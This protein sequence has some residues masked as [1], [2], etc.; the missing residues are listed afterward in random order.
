MRHNRGKDMKLKHKLPLMNL[1]LL[2][3]GFI[4][5][6]IGSINALQNFVATNQKEMAFEKIGM[7]AREIENTINRGIK[8][9]TMMSENES[10]K[11]MQWDLIKPY[12]MHRLE[13]SPFNKVGI[14]FP[15][16]SYYITS[17]P[18]QSNLAERQ[19]VNDALKGNTVISEPLYSKSD[20]AYQ[21]VIAMPILENDE[22]KGLIIGGILMQDIE[23]MIKALNINQSGY[24]FLSNN[25]GEIIIH[26]KLEN[27][28]NRNMYN[29]LQL[30]TNGFNNTSGNLT[31]KDMKGVTSYAFY[32]YLELPGWYVVISVPQR[33]IYKPI[34]G[35][36]I[37]TTLV[38]LIVLLILGI[39]IYTIVKRFFRPIDR[40]VSDMKRVESGEYA[41][42][43]PVH[44]EDEIGEI[45]RQFNNTI[46]GI[47]LRDEELQALNEE[48]AASFEEING[49]NEKLT[50]AHEAISN[51][52]MKQ[53]MIN[54]LGENLYLISD[55]EELLTTILLHTGEMINSKKSAIFILN[56][57]TNCFS[58]ISA[59]N[60]T[61]EERQHLV[62]Q[63]DEGAFK[64][65]LENKTEL[66]IENI[67]QDYRYKDITNEMDNKML[68]Q[69]PIFD[70]DNEVIGV[71]SYSSDN[72]N[73]DFIPFVKQIS[74]IISI[75][76][77]NTSLITQMKSTYF[78]I[79]VALVKAMELKDTYTKG[80]SERVMNYSLMMGK[81]LNLSKDEIEILRHGSI[82]HDIG[83]LGVPENLLTKSSTLDLD[84]Y[85]MIKNHPSIGEAFISNMKFLDDVKPIIRNH[86][87][88]IDGEGYPDGLLGDNIPL[89]AKIVAIA[90]AYDAMTSQ[91]SYR[92]SMLMED[93]IEELKQHSGTQFDAELVEL[94]IR[95]ISQ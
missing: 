77:L 30:N 16:K 58:I 44:R 64:W 39:G 51:N 32:N 33:D 29:Y 83:K 75:T 7:Q 41:I 45:T 67:N 36:L 24:G 14:V 40:L 21:I 27:L 72:L 53:K 94:F 78:D 59:E 34:T 49:A 19:Y 18:V 55:Y 88:R 68:L 63:K 85:D 26:P 3:L 20:G 42:Q 4:M 62:F 2:I 66:F 87:E 22:V 52:L 37:K 15:D 92:L 28:V 46:E 84:E 73:L 70:E 5:L 31:Y 69:L 13:D 11:T 80:H 61:M 65:I 6:W 81:E 43:V 25:Q 89:L 79:I 12:A 50:F 82:L 76:I 17:N 74:K 71:I 86:H 8:Q 90:D 57:E 23:D 93:A 47:S 91:R 38:F 48:L 9:L 1:G 10:V 54:Q 60:Y 56:E 35:L 95:L